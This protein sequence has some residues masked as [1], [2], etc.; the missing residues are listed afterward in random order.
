M[1]DVSKEHT[2]V[3]GR[4][5]QGELGTVMVLCVGH[6]GKILLISRKNGDSSTDLSWERKS[7]SRTILTVHRS[8]APVES[9]TVIL[10]PS[11]DGALLR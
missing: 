5:A 7:D 11:T 9:E 8:N 6:R 3:P 10:S 2:V 4:K 1:L